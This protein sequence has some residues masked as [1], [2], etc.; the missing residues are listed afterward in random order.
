M[1][2]CF[3]YAASLVFQHLLILNDQAPSS[4]YSLS[5]PLGCQDLLRTRGVFK[6]DFGVHSTNGALTGS[7]AICDLDWAIGPMVVSSFVQWAS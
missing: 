1:I 2:L 3:L 6:W 7:E 5:W 4:F